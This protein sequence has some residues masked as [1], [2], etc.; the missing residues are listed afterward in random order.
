MSTLTTQGD[1]VLL[2]SRGEWWAGVLRLSLAFR[3]SSPHWTTTLSCHRDCRWNRG[4]WKRSRY[5]WWK[6]Y[7]VLLGAAGPCGRSWAPPSLD[8]GLCPDFAGP[9]LCCRTVPTSLPLIPNS[10]RVFTPTFPFVLL[11]IFH[12]SCLF[13]LTSLHIFPPKFM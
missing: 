6:N 12:P 1:Q 4:C 8:A 13:S 7:C 3:T 11:S 10:K 5:R 9:V 2:S